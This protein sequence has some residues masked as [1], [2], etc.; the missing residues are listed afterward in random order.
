[1]SNA[2]DKWLEVYGRVN[3]PIEVPS[4]VGGHQILVEDLT[5]AEAVL[6]LHFCKP[7]SVIVIDLL[8]GWLSPFLQGT[9]DTIKYKELCTASHKTGIDYAQR[10]ILFWDA[11]LPHWLHY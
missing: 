7:N 5:E 9:W 2:I 10:W 3:L 6:H 8:W 11:T 4:V 1:M